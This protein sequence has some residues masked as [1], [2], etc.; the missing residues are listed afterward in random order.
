MSKKKDTAKTTKKTLT[1]KTVAK[2]PVIKKVIEENVKPS[3][4]EKAD[5]YIYTVG[6]RKAAVAQIRLYKKGEGKIIINKHDYK[7]YFP[8][9]EFQKIVTAPLV[10]VGED[11]QHDI[12]VVVR[13]GGIRGQAEAIRL[14]ISRA[15]IEL[16]KD[17]RPVL[18]ANGFLTRDPRVKERKKPG[19]KRARRAP[20]WS[21]R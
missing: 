14:G 13:G 5:L 12:T 17:C 4:K 1:K 9:F 10:L 20:Q 2:K 8:F 21:K 16:N 11:N 15:L 6:R 19:L 7:K 3:G 18:K